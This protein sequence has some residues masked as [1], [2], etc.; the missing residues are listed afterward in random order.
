[1]IK[2]LSEI[3]TSLIALSGTD[4]VLSEHQFTEDE[5]KCLN[6]LWQLL[7]PF[8]RATQLLSTECM[9]SL[10]TFFPILRALLIHLAK[11]DW[12]VSNTVQQV[13]DALRFH[14]AQRW[15]TVKG[16]EPWCL[17]TVLDP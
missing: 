10:S 15:P 17:S 2:R 14:L 9:P 8:N 4:S 6:L 12:C 3:K 1:M 16:T 5:W 13:R 11:D 7:K